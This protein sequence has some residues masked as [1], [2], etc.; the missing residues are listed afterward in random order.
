[1]LINLKEYHRPR[2]VAEAVWMVRDG[3]GQTAVLAGGTE[4]VGRDEPGL[5]VVVDLKG[6]GLDTCEEQAGEWRVGAMATLAELL[7]TPGPAEAAGSILGRAIRQAAPATIR[8]AA[9]LGGTLAGLKGGD[10]IPTA[11]LALGASVTLA[12]PEPREMPLSAFLAHREAALERAVLTHVTIP[13]EAV[14]GG[15]SWVSRTPADRAIVV[16]AATVD[17]RGRRRVAIGGLAPYARH[18]DPGMQLW[19]LVEDHRATGEYRR[20]VAPILIR[21]ALEEAGAL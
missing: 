16:A 13:R 20:Q 21:R 4:L 17:E 12:E 11:L 7:E 14:R 10:E 9:T 15:I 5:K 1:V 2:S 18:V 3:R 19:A 8:A 6:L